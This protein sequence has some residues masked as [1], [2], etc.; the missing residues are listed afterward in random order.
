MV[1]LGLSPQDIFSL[2]RVAG[3]FDGKKEVGI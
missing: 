2:Q 1:E 3:Y